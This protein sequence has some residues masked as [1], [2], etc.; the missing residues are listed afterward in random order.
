[1][2]TVG[3]LTKGGCLG[4]KRSGDEVE[5]LKRFKT[6]LGLSDEEAAPVHITVGQRVMRGRIEAPDRYSE[7]QER[8]VRARP[9]LPPSKAAHVSSRGLCVLFSL[10]LRPFQPISAISK[11]RR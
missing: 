6:A 3:G 4:A 9:P 2:W 7:A 11:N 8:R 10:H 1:M 5:R